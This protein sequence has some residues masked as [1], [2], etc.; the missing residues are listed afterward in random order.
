MKNIVY[1]FKQNIKWLIGDIIEYN[2]QLL[3]VILWCCE[4]FFNADIDAF[5]DK[6]IEDLVIDEENDYVIE[7]FLFLPKYVD[8]KVRWLTTKKILRAH[9][10]FIFKN[11]K[12]LKTQLNVE[13]ID[14]KHICKKC[15]IRAVCNGT[16]LI[17]ESI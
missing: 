15:M 17:K 8:G 11:K 14:C 6:F 10:T 3:T 4:K 9:G 12:I 13:Y 16:N 1:S 7:R 5:L 2:A